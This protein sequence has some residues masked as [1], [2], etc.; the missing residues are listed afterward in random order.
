MDTTAQTIAAY[1]E[2]RIVSPDLATWNSLPHTQMVTEKRA[3]SSPY[4][5]GSDMQPRD[6]RTLRRWRTANPRRGPAFVK[7]GGRYYYTIGALRDFYERC[8]RGM[9]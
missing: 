3:A 1:Q 9:Q 8:Q 5:G 7:I 4:I 2:C 6:A